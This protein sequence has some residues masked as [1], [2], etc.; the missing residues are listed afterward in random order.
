GEEAIEVGNG[1]WRISSMMPILSEGDV[2]GGVMCLKENPG[3][4]SE[5][6]KALIR[7]AGIF[8]GRQLEE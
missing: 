2:I 6:E 8:L 7:T 5:T 4:V 3:E 1:S